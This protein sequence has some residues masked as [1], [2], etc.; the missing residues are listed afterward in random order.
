M[1]YKIGDTVRITDGKYYR[2]E[3]IVKAIP[4]D[5]RPAYIVATEGYQYGFW[6]YE[7]NMEPYKITE[8]LSYLLEEKYWD[9]FIPDDVDPGRFF[10]E[11][12]EIYPAYNDDNNIKKRIFQVSVFTGNSE[13]PVPHMHVFYDGKK[14]KANTAFICLGKAEYAPQHKKTTKILNS[15]EIKDLITFLTT[16]IPKYYE[17]GDITCWEAAVKLWLSGQDKK[18]MST[19]KKYFDTDE[20]GNIIM[21]DYT[22]LS[23]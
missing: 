4:N 9:Q 7:L 6:A 14:N 15:Q 5:T 3:G 18:Y 22:K 17:L 19:W 20:N 16:K 8:D 21:P 2:E 1:R 12:A 23:L 11:M 13:G 10:L